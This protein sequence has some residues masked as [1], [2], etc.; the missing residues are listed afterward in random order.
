[1]TFRSLRR[2]TMTR[3]RR[4]RRRWRAFL[5]ID[6]ISFDCFFTSTLWRVQVTATTHDDADQEMAALLAGAYNDVKQMLSQNR[7]AL[8]AAIEALLEKT[9]LSGQEVSSLNSIAK[10][11]IRN[12]NVSWLIETSTMRGTPR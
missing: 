6:I 3:A 2:P 5:K 7:V 1:M 8:D 4:W 12:K 11:P 9:T 10:E